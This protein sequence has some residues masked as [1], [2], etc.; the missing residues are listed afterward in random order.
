M[1]KK[2]EFVISVD[3]KEVW[4]GMNPKKKY[5]EIRKKNPKKRV[6]VSWQ[7]HE[8]VLVCIII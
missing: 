8:D 2:Y 7:T 6:S 3:N 1:E 4:R 5:V